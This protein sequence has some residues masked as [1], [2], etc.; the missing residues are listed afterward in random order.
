MADTTTTNYSLTKPEVG[1]SEDTWG[2]KL[3]TNLDTIDTT[4]FAKVDI[5]GDTMTG[6]L[7]FGDNVKAQFGASNDLQIY[8]N[9]SHSYISDQG[10]GNLLVLADQFEVNNAANTE[11]KIVATTDGAVTLYYDNSA[12]LA[13]T[14]TGINVSHTAPEIKLTDTDTNYV[15]QI[16][17]A[18][19]TIYIEADTG[20]GASSTF[21]SCKIDTVERMRL[22]ADGD[23]HAD[24]DVIAYSTT[25]SDER[26]KEN[27]V[28]IDD[29]LNKVAQLNGY[30]FSY[31]ADGKISAGVI[32]QEVEK[33]L[34]EA[35]S[36]KELPLKADDG[37]EYKVV[38]YDALH[39]LLIE[40]I[41]ELKAEIEV[42]KGAK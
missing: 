5:A 6:A 26:L 18:N 37:Q 39:G 22:E 9:G 38:N 10:T 36:E 30:T 3:N 12:K 34:P 28:G 13:T 16:K 23:L 17:A 31:K 41:K 15:G 1:A 40:A 4:L 20:N 33:V 2:T 24:G 19:G 7:N 42:L 25:I 11:N 14:S 35:V 8:H 21:I 27:I 29:A 32:A